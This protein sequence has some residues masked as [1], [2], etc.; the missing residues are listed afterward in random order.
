MER[1][2]WLTPVVVCGGSACRGRR[3]KEWERLCE[4]LDDAGLCAERAKCLGICEGPV[5]VVTIGDRQEVV[6]S[7]RSGK[8]QRRLID[9][10]LRQKRSRLPSVITGKK[11]TKAL[12]RAV[13]SLVGAR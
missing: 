1:E 9:A 4:R 6:G 8:R 12:A 2:A 11:R 7:L 10:V 5:A 13:K 3:E